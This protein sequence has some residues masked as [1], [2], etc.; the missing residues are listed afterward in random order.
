VSEKERIKVTDPTS[1]RKQ[2]DYDE[3]DI[4]HLMRVRDWHDWKE[5]VAWLREEGDNDNEL[6]PGEVRQM[7]A[8]F[9]ELQRRGMPFT[10]DPHRV[11]EAARNR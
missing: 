11:Y 2:K 8:D 10:T 9:E 5:I 3:S 7:I 1:D 4:Q 6:T